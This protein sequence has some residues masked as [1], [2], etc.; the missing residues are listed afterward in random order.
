MEVSGVNSIQNK[1]QSIEGGKTLGKEDFLNL[2]IKQLSYQDP[3][4][5]MDSTQF[6]SQ[7]SQFSSLEQLSNINTTLNDVLSFQ[8]SMQNASVS[9]LI[10]RT[11]KVAGNAAYLGH[12]ADIGYELS[13]DAASVE[14][15][16][17]DGTGKLVV[18]KEAGAQSQGVNTFVWD[19]EDAMGN[20]MPE[21]TYTFDVHAKDGSEKDIGVSSNSS[22]K[23]TGVVFKDSSTYLVLDNG[24]NIH[25]SEIQSIQ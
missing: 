6:T 23:V 25:L 24:I 20:K 19:G 16:I 18:S 21:G 5:P 15:S 22:G 11:V 12:T 17:Y 8:H 7:L 3:L 9:N 1:I 10:G 14:I 2:L 13:D 4:S